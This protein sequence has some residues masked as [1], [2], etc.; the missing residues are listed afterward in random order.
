M[1]LGVE[2]GLDPV[3]IVLDGD[4]APLRKKRG[5]SFPIFGP[6]LLW[7]NGWM[8]QDA[9]WYGGR[10][11]PRRLCV[12]CGTSCAQWFTDVCST[13]HDSTWKTAAST[14]RTL[15]VGSTCSLLAAVSCLCCDTVV[16]CSVAQQARGPG[17]RYQISSRPDAFCGQFPSWPENFSFLVLLAY[18][19]H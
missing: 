14:P 13:R 8:H 16:R 9:T 6:F 17:T 4:T 7:P 18:T 12:R 15:L 19:A 1:A 2:L 3:P 5:Q 10:P 11:Q